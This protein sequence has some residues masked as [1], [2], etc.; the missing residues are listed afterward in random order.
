MKDKMLCQIINANARPPRIVIRG[1]I[2]N[3]TFFFRDN[4]IY[5][6]TG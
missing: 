6:P 2:T 1:S 3:D 5:L 4:K